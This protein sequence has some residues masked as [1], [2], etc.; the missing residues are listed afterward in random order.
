M[1]LAYTQSYDAKPEQVVA[2]LKSPDFIAELAKQAG[3]QQHDLEVNGEAFTVTLSVA[4]PPA[5][6][7]FIGDT[8]TVKQRF[9]FAQPKPDGTIDGT[10]DLEIAGAPVDARADI[11]VNPDGAAKS[12][13]GF[14]GDLD[15]RIPLLGGQIEQQVEPL[16]GKGLER[17]EKTAK[18]WLAK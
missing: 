1:K 10:L 14:D 5:A 2:M 18:Q 4:A 9:R 12:V 17:I 7:G 16:I 6:R 11:T 3:A 15:V 8:F 13:V